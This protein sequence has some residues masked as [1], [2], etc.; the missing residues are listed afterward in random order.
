VKT[1]LKYPRGTLLRAKYTTTIPIAEQ[2]TTYK[3]KTCAPEQATIAYAGNA[4]DGT[5]RRKNQSHSFLRYITF[6][7]VS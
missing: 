1:Y 2:E 4:T 5:R 6:S 7:K 3:K